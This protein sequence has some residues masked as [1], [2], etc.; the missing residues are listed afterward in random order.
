M[1]SKPDKKI[2]TWTQSIK[3]RKIS[4]KLLGES[5]KVE[6]KRKDILKQKDPGLLVVRLP[7]AE[8]RA[9]TEN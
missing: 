4:D 8:K 5:G 1:Y 9:K 7:G 2:E 3:K 6:R